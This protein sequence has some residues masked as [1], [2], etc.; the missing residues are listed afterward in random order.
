MV[1]IFLKFQVLYGITPIFAKLS[2]P[3]L[4]HQKHNGEE[5]IIIPRRQQGKEWP[6]KMQAGR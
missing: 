5:K 1:Y 4:V 2:S 6:N 3:N